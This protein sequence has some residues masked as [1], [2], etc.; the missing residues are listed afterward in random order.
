MDGAENDV[1]I[2]RLRG[3]WAVRRRGPEIQSSSMPSSTGSPADF[4]SFNR[5]N[6]VR[7]SSR[8]VIAP[9]RLRGGN[10][11]WV[12]AVDYPTSRAED[13]NASWKRKRCS[14]RA[15]CCTPLSPGVLNVQVDPL[16]RHRRRFA[17]RLQVNVRVDVHAA[18]L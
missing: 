6:V 14:V 13:S 15:I 8:N 18:L 16:P 10:Q 9:V 17:V 7:H 12:F 11:R 1:P 3:S 5:P 2:V 4:A